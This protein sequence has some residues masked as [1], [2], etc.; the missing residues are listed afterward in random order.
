MLPPG[1][2]VA[3]FIPC[4]TEQ[5]FPETGMALAKLLRYF[6]MTPVYPPRQ[7]CCGQPAFNSGHRDLVIPLAERL[8]R[9]FEPYDWVVAPSGSCVSM[10]KVHYG[11]LN[12][13][14]AAFQ[15]WQNLQSR[16][17]E[18]TQFLYHQLGL[19]E[20]NG[21]FSGKVVLHQSCHARRELGVDRE[22]VELLT[23][24][25]DLELVVPPGAEEC[26]GF[27]GT[28]AVKFPELSTA[29]GLDKVAAIRQS[30][31]DYMTALD[32]SCLMQ[33]YGIMRR[34]G[35]SI[36]PLHVLRILAQSLNLE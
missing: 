24:I 20:I 7:T 14:Q 2:K 30:G 29:I 15:R 17:Y 3:L 8:L 23:S 16:I 31:A 4:Y 26:C 6:G 11:Q 1:T 10:V 21:S 33:L 18:G 25:R 28:F 13:S 34:R 27:G 19:C 32:D 12:L 9:L 35:Y 22:P 36:R 5:V